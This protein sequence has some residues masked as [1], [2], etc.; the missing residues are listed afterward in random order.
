MPEGFISLDVLKYVAFSK[1][2]VNA[3]SIVPNDYQLD[4]VYF[5]VIIYADAEVC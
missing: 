1:K 3:T 4:L 5:E 2:A